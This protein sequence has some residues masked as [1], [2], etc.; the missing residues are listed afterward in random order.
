[1]RTIVLLRGLPGCGKSTWVKDHNLEAY[2]LSP[3][4]IREMCYVP[5]LNPDGSRSICTEDDDKVWNIFNT[6]VEARMQNGDFVI[7]DATNISAKEMNRYKN[8]AHTYKYRIFCVDFTDIPLE[9]VKKQNMLREEKRRVSEQTIYKFYNR[10][11]KSENQVPAGIT[12]I[13]PEEYEKLLLTP[14]NLDKYNKI[15]CIGDIHGCY[16]VLME[17]LKDGLKEDE[18]YIFLGDYIDRGL[19]N[20]ETVNYLMSIVNLPNVLMLEGNH[21]KWLNMWSYNTK[22]YSKEFEENTRLQLEHAGVKRKMVKNLYRKLAQCAYIEFRR[23]TYFI[24]HGGISTIRRNPIFISTNQMISGVG[25]YSDVKEVEETFDKT[26]PDNFYQIHAHRNFGYPIHSTE[27]NYNLE[28]EVERGGYLRA[29]Q[30]SDIGIEEY[31]LKNE[32]YKKPDFSSV[33]TAIKSLRRDPYIKEKKFGNISSFNFTREA[34]NKRNWNERTVTARGLYLN[35]KT[36]EIV[37]RGYNKFFAV[38][39]VPE[40]Q[41]ERLKEKFV[42]PLHVYVKENGFLGMV[43]LNRETNDLFITT[44][45]DP[46]GIAAKWMRDMFYDKFDTEK[47]NA[48]KRM[49]ADQKVTLAFECVDQEHDPHIIDYDESELYLLDAIYNEFEFQKV[50]YEKLRLIGK[51]YGFQVKELAYTLSD[52]DEFMT[53]YT[54]IMAQKEDYLYN[55]KPIE[56]FVIEDQNHFMVKMKLDYY[57]KWKMFRGLAARIDSIDFEFLNKEERDFLLFVQKLYEEG[58]I[59]K[60][61]LSSNICNLRKLYLEEKAI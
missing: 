31:E 9:Q 20:A 33:R 6:M 1:M 58:R 21:E 3:D 60:D 47:M 41:I 26:M 34:F 17:Y 8:L 23:N 57:K 11:T 39:E 52:W 30:I 40:T 50:P 18:Y 25:G 4:Q 22:A 16:T 24:S 48:F 32:I 35:T 28:G 53:W 14:L 15:H 19:E 54:E 38:N 42:Y 55:G 27:R 44:K 37:C 13:K 49:L 7:V 45:S 12:V 61:D 10:L 51:E 46:S 43:S 56:G 5:A 59:S 36:E 2:A 29:I